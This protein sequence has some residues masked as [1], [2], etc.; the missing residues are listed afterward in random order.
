MRYGRT[1]T[2]SKVS[3]ATTLG[4]LAILAF[5]LIAPVGAGA[6]NTTTLM[7]ASLPSARDGTAAATLNGYV[8][9]FGGDTGV[10]SNQIVRY[11]PIVDQTTLMAATL[12]TPRSGAAAVAAGSVAYLFGG[13]NS[14]TYSQ[15][16]VRYDPA[17]D[18]ATPMGA[19]LPSGRSYTSAVWT[20]S[21]AYLFGGG[22][23]CGTYCTT[24]QIVRYDPATDTV[25]VMS[26]K[27]P[28]PRYGTSAV[29]TGTHAYIF[30]GVTAS[31]NTEHA[32]I[33][34]YDPV[35]D[36]LDVLSATLPAPRYHT[37]AAYLD[38]RAFIMGGFP[39]A[40]FPNYCKQIVSFEPTGSTVAIESTTLT[41]GRYL[42]SAAARGSQIYVFGGYDGARSDDVLRFSPGAAPAPTN[43]APIIGPVQDQSVVTGDTLN[44]VI[45][46]QDADND[47]LTLSILGLPSGASFTDNGDAT[48]HLLWQ[49]APGDEG[50]YTLTVRADDGYTSVSKQFLV[51]VDDD[52]PPMIDII[53]DQTV[54][55]GAHLTLAVRAS[56]PAN[57]PLTLS[58]SPLPANAIFT[59]HSDGTGDL[60]WTVGY[61]QAGVY[62]LTLQ[63]SDPA[64]SASRTFQVTVLEL[65]RPPVWGAAPAAR[66][67][68]SSPTTLAFVATDPDADTIVLS[69]PVLPV[70]AFFADLG[71][72]MG[73]VTWLPS[74]QQ[75]GTH[76]MRIVADA[77]AASVPFEHSVAVVAPYSFTLKPIG[78]GFM[79]AK[80]GEQLVMDA[81]LTNTGYYADSYTFRGQDALSPSQ[82]WP[83]AV[84]PTT[85]LAPGE[86]TIVTLL[87]DVPA[88]ATIARPRLS[89]TSAGQVDVQKTLTSVVTVPIYLDVRLDDPTPA[90]ADLSMLDITG[91]AQASWY[92]GSPVVGQAIRVTAVIPAFDRIG[93]E[94]QGA[95]DS[96]G[97]FAFAFSNDVAASLP[98]EHELRATVH[99]YGRTDA[100][101]LSYTVGPL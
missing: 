6:P 100:D 10:R 97:T 37:S 21:A 36:Q 47:A 49:T 13:W 53:P 1:D 66:I 27:L 63:A 12:P 72:G 55:E 50:V 93:A 34:R 58:L 69:A 22:T 89:A 59:D 70:G 85:T 17:T 88:H 101:S 95:T 64:Q 75:I 80:P 25:S 33:L 42:T 31:T 82:A 54:V 74:A 68:A 76:A 87:V 56:D 78:F 81:R 51:T 65:D 18:T 3:R 32:Q 44:T 79:D 15:Q 99:R 84:P 29:W 71:N 24:D 4:V 98:G 52:P 60:D 14:G 39:C 46:A 9:V 38:G 41:T 5:Q 40:T 11:D 62:A 77:G 26:A 45:T 48:G 73:E 90:L 23:V 43:Q 61:G 16:I 2:Q 7:S 83:L 28:T 94:R 19:Q 30:G 91:V 20:G 8:Y 92:D 67:V 57:D 35:V 96:T 86:Q